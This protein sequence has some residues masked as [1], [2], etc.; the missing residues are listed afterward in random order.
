M[1]DL[2]VEYVGLKMKNPLLAA[3]ATETKDA[4]TMKKAVDA[5]FGG[6]VVKSLYGNS[7][8]VARR[9]HRPRFQLLHWDPKTTD[10][11]KAPD[12]FILYSIEQGSQFNYEEWFEDVNKAKKLIGND[13]VVIGSIMAGSFEEWDEILTK[14]MPGTEMDALEIDLS[15]PHMKEVHA[16]Y[17]V[18][19]GADPVH[20][21]KLVKFVKERMPAGMPLIPKLTPQTANMV[22]VA[23]ACEE[24]GADAICAHNRMMA[25]DIDIEK[26]APSVWP[27]YGGWGGPWMLPYMQMWISKLAP[28][29][30]IPITCTNGVWK[31]QDIISTIMAGA[32]TV[33]SCTAIL[34]KGFG[35]VQDW[36]TNVN[37]WMDEKG[38][39]SFDEIKGIA[40]KNMIPVGE[41]PRNQPG[42]YAVVDPEKCTAC[43]WCEKICLYE[44]PKV[45]GECAEI[46]PDKC[47]GCGM[48]WQVCPLKAIEMTKPAC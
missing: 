11:L 23:K 40:L 35:A 37:K 29:V 16:E 24:N 48:C 28:A 8:K 46:D 39:K 18:A 44:A 34:V 42:V 47:D 31:W 43:G 22:A 5:G 32:T 10:P 25:L 33:Q 2:S 13:G 26:A 36:L 20:A 15:C 21:G 38:Y 7:A 19:L 9:W 6:V 3:S 27:C 1:A 17:G 4:K 30:K 12:G 14:Y 41:I 45:N